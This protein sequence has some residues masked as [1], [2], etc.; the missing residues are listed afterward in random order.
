VA[1]ADQLGD[2]SPVPGDRLF[3]SPAGRVSAG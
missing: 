1:D 3:G 2:V